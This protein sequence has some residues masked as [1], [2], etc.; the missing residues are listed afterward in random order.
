[1]LNGIVTLRFGI[2]SFI[3]TLGAMMVWRGIVLLATG[4]WPPEYPTAADPLK[5]ILVGKGG[6][7]LHLPPLVRGDHRS[8]LDPHWSGTGSVTGRTPPGAT[9][10][11]RG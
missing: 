6:P 7:H 8:P 10:P 2:P 4:G 5:A 9:S 3:T 11:R 1:M